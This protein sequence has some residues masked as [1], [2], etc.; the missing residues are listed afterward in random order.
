MTHADIIIELKNGTF[1][2]ADVC[3]S[4]YPDGVGR[5]LLEYYKD[6]DTVLELVQIGQFSPLSETPEMT[7][8][9]NMCEEDESEGTHP[10]PLTAEEL[11]AE[12]YKMYPTKDHFFGP[13]Q[14]LGEFYYTQFSGGY[15]YLW[16][17]NKWWYQEQVQKDGKWVMTDWMILTSEWIDKYPMGGE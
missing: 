2:L 1:L 15:R 5:T 4:G 16:R 11:A 14:K 17:D 6:Y 10:V 3:S 12:T 8:E 7:R 9:D 13:D